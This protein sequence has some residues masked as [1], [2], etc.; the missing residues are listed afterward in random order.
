M[1]DHEQVSSAN[2]YAAPSASLLQ[3]LNVDRYQLAGRGRRFAAAFIDDS[4]QLAFLALS[5][6]LIVRYF[7][8]FFRQVSASQF[9][10]VLIGPIFAF[11]TFLLLHG[12]FLAEDGQTIGKLFCSIRI[13]RTDGS[14]AGI[15]RILFRRYGPV[16]ALGL[17]PTIGWVF[18]LIDALFIF[19]SSR[20]CL[21]DL[22]AD[23]I[24]VQV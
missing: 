17:I 16:L 11:V 5:Y 23:T 1:N 7:P 12:K 19:Q 3:E 10:F 22:L 24:V 20:K 15:W 13:V 4:L 18:R 14:D 21:H 6:Y 2:I 9:P 8:S